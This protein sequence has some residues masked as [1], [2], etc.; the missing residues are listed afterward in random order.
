M[1]STYTWGLKERRVQLV[2]AT[3]F[4]TKPV[5]PNVFLPSVVF[6]LLQLKRLKNNFSTKISWLLTLAPGQ[7]P[8]NPQLRL[9]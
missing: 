4:E 7:Y 1:P 2:T 6:P 8:P 3:G 5:K 9:V